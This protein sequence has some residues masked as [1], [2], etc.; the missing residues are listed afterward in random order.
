MLFLTIGQK[1]IIEFDGDQSLVL[2]DCTGFGRNQRG[3]R[4]GFL[5]GL[6]ALPERYLSYQDQLLSVAPRFVGDSL[7]TTDGDSLA[8][9]VVFITVFPDLGVVG[10]EDFVSAGKA[11]MFKVPSEGWT[12]HKSKLQSFGVQLP[13]WALVGEDFE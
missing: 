10:D 9:N 6:S 11:F 3:M 4:V 1:Y 8:V 5:K 7:E 12:L 2:V 13:S